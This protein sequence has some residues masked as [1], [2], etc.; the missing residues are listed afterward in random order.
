MRALSKESHYGQL[1][2]AISCKGCATSNPLFRSYSLR[3]NTQGMSCQTWYATQEH[4]K[5]CWTYCIHSKPMRTLFQN[6][7]RTCCIHSKPMRTL[8]HQNYGRTCCI[9]TKP[10]TTLFHQNDVLLS[11]LYRIILGWL[12]SSIRRRKRACDDVTA[13]QKIAVLQCCVWLL[14]EMPS[15]HAV[16]GLNNRKSGVNRH[17]GFV[18]FQKTWKCSLLGAYYSLNHGTTHCIF[19]S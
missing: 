3:S 9:H 2:G 17:R 8:F 6:Y 13:S 14:A 15:S 19:Q 18:N 16:F 7:G 1:F 12:D 11:M 10:T 5:D 4:F